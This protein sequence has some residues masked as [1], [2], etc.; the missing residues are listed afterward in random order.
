MYKVLEYLA[1]V[2]PHFFRFE[3]IFYHQNVYLCINDAQDYTC[4]YGCFLRGG[5]AA[6]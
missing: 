1:T 6:G 4:G 3:V 5:G 2:L